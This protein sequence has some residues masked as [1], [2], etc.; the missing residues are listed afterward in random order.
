MLSGSSPSIAVTSAFTGFLSSVL[1][2]INFSSRL[3][4]LNRQRVD[5]I[6]PSI[7]S[8]QR[9]LLSLAD[10]VAFVMEKARSDS[11]LTH[12]WPVS[13]KWKASS[14]N[15]GKLPPCEWSTFDSTRK[16]DFHPKFPGQR[17]GEVNAELP[18]VS[19]MELG[20]ERRVS[21]GTYKYGHALLFVLLQVNASTT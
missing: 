19:D 6:C 18:E 12:L 2:P 4:K 3:C 11:A 14:N 10:I 9:R 13:G 5:H 15:K 16:D 21:H 8:C 7:F 17:H 20:G 1:S